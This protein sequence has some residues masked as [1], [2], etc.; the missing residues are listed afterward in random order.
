MSGLDDTQYCRSC[1]AYANRIADLEDALT[2][3]IAA[4]DKAANILRNQQLQDDPDNMPPEYYQALAEFGTNV[5]AA[6]ELLTQP[7]KAG[8]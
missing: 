4:R 8:Q 2:K 1:A 5:T 7:K 3:I 6:E